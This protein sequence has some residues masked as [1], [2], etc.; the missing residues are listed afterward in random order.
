MSGTGEFDLI[1]RYFTRPARR[2]P[3]GVGDDCALL[4]PAAG[5]QLA[6]STDMLVE[7]RHF[8]STVDPARL[9]HKA[10]AVNLSDLAACGARPLAFTLA[11]SLPAVDAAW[12]EGFSRGLFA[13]ADAHGCELVGGDTTRGPLNLCITVFGEVPAGAALLRSGA[14]AGDDVWVSG[15]LG[16][17]RLALEVFRGTLALPADSFELARGRMEQ[18][19]PR[20]ALGMALRGIATAA[21]DI[22]DGLVG[23]LGHI[24]KASGVGARLDADA[25]AKLLATGDSTGLD[26]DLRRLCA[27]AGGDDYELAFTAPPAARAAVEQAGRASAT[28]VTRIGAIEAEAG[29][30][31]VDAQGAAVT[32]RFASFDHFA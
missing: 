24:L 5:M 14:R 26:I 28:P 30:R 12:L 27:L 19:T 21:V 20:V 4:A 25:A 3:L 6:V 8:L 13:L 22:S 32:Q 10:L 1:A 18:P 9:G 2:S 16:D 7:G 31:L 17:A 15:T 29:L 23:D 11:L